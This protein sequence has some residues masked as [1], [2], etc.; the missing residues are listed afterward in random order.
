MITARKPKV[1]SSS[2]SSKSKGAGRGK[3]IYHHIPSASAN[4]LRGTLY[5][6]QHWEELPPA[7]NGE[8]PSTVL[9][10]ALTRDGRQ[11]YLLYFICV[12][13]VVI[14][15]IIFLL[16]LARTLTPNQPQ[17]MYVVTPPQPTPWL[18]KL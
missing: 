5:D 1:K 14:L 18:R 9:K 17:A 13:V 11:M 16:K 12:V 8:S 4:S 7:V 6:L 15:I 3:R 2:N 10:Y